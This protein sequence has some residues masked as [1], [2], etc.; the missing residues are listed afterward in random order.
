MSGDLLVIADKYTDSFLHNEEFDWDIAEEATYNPDYVKLHYKL[1]QRNLFVS[2]ENV[3]ISPDMIRGKCY[4]FL[5]TMVDSPMDVLT[6]ENKFFFLLA[7]DVS[8]QEV[9]EDKGSI[10]IGSAY[11]AE[12][13]DC[14]GGGSS[15]DVED[16][17]LIW[18]P[19]KCSDKT[20]SQLSCA[21]RSVQA[22]KNLAKTNPKLR[23]MQVHRDV[24]L[25]GAM[26]IL[27]RENYDMK[28]A[29]LSIV[30]DDSLTL[31][32]IDS[33]TRD[34]VLIFERCLYKYGK[35]FNY[36]RQEF[37]PWKSW[38]SI[39][40][41][42]YQWKGTDGYKQWKNDY[43]SD[44]GELKDIEV[45][46][47][48]WL[49]PALTGSETTSSKCPGCGKVPKVRGCWFSWGP[50]TEPVRICKTCAL[51]WKQFAGFPDSPTLESKVW[52][53]SSPSIIGLPHSKLFKCETDGCNKAFRC[54][55]GLRRHQ[56]ISHGDP[57]RGQLFLCTEESLAA[58]KCLGTKTMRL[59]AR[60]PCQAARNR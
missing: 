21:V 5:L 2:K 41:F 60:R 27:N 24:H 12:L 23:P 32:D 37:L 9:H 48:E 56:V 6:N 55:S 10:M 47:T 7:Y 38:Q 52:E 19:E 46:V 58:R 31:D 29:G 35:Q 30:Q 42:Y 13:P 39:I 3:I 51:H 8:N 16:D 20:Y 28:T 43:C 18:D 17:Q 25:F 26:E 44:Q 57:S 36:I 22:Y 54:K 53:S 45:A 59:I 15:T 33:W 4:V 11:Q 14:E 40:S 1:L 49:L 34:E 50:V